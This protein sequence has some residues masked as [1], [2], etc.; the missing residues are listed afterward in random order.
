MCSGQGPINT[1]K[2]KDGVQYT[3]QGLPWL[4]DFIRSTGKPSEIVAR[5]SS[6]QAQDN[7][8]TT[9]MSSGPSTSGTVG[10]GGGFVTRR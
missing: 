2:G 7:P 8:S 1:I 3:G 6:P 10:S 4:V 5:R 9:T